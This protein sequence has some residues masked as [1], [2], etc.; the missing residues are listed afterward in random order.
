MHISDL[1]Y[2]CKITFTPVIGKVYYL[3]EE[4]DGTRYLSLLSPKDWGSK[5]VDVYLA[6]VK[7]NA[8][9]TWKVLDST[10]E[11]F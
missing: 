3:Y 7:L 9:H 4:K 6:E 11:L 8:D 2:D 5:L 1:I 10:I